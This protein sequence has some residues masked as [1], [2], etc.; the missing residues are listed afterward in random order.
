M[1]HYLLYMSRF[2]FGSLNRVSGSNAQNSDHDTRKR[3]GSQCTTISQRKQADYFYKKL[4]NEKTICRKF[5]YNSE[6]I[7]ETIMPEYNSIIDRYIL[8]NLHTW[9]EHSQEKE[10]IKYLKYNVIIGNH[11]VI[12]VEK[13]NRFFKV[14]LSKIPIEIHKEMYGLVFNYILLYVRQ[15]KICDFVIL[16]D[17][18]AQ[19][20]IENKTILRMVDEIACICTFIYEK[21]LIQTTH[22]N[23]IWMRFT[24]IL[25]APYL[26]QSEKKVSK[27]A[28]IYNIY[29]NNLKTLYKHKKLYLNDEKE[30]LVT[31]MIYSFFAEETCTL[32]DWIMLMTIIIEYKDPKII[33]IIAFLVSE[34]N[35]NLLKNLK[36]NEGFHLVLKNY[37]IN[38][39][40]LSYFKNNIKLIEEVGNI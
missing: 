31:Y 8:T 36:R 9:K 28:S 1:L 24:G 12:L 16:D 17:Q 40:R 30:P 35:P 4:L 6:E 11:G 37:C 32:N 39:K 21:I 23:T 13:F 34:R 3:Q 25:M 5:L 29:K 33:Y 19:N 26:G 27:T 38:K 22:I 7:D 10:E 14:I 18:N 20:D 15:Y 2:V